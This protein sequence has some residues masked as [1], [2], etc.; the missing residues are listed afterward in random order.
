[1]ADGNIGSGDSKNKVIETQNFSI[2]GHLLRWYDTA[3]QISNIS[4]ISTAPLPT[5]RFP[6]WTLAGAVIGMVLLSQE[7]YYSD[8]STFQVIGMGVLTVCVIAIIAWATV[9]QD[10]KEKKYLH[11]FLNSGYVYS[12]VFRD[13][14][15]LKQVLQLLADIIET[16]T[17]PNMN[18]NVNIHDCNVTDSQGNLINIP[19]R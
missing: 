12:F 7:S 5:P 3:I 15:F 2:R 6:L 10:A 11:I 13:Q 4:M 17:T 14:D 16:G 18:F 19:L 9:V 8:F 1:M